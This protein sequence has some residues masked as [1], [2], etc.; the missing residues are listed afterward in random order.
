MSKIILYFGVVREQRFVIFC[1]VGCS[2]ISHVLPGFSSGLGVTAWITSQREG[3]AGRF[4]DNGWAAD[5][6][7]E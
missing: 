2:L 6:T 7:R 4:L 3:L 1:K 5:S